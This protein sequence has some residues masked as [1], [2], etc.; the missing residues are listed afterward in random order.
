MLSEKDAAIVWQSSGKFPND[1]TPTTDYIYIRFHGLTGYRYS[2]NK[3]DLESWAEIVQNQLKE[4]RDAQIY[5]NN[6]GGNA[7]D[8]AIM[9]RKLLN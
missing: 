9:M 6:P 2:Y 8:S 5:F 1:C 4:G 7:V 3:S